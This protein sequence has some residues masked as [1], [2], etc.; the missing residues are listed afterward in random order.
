MH[1]TW[2]SSYFSFLHVV[3][4][5]SGILW[6]YQVHSNQSFLCRT[7]WKRDN[8]DSFPLLGDRQF[9]YLT[10][11]SVGFSKNRRYKLRQKQH[12]DT[13]HEHHQRRLIHRFAIQRSEIYH[14]FKAACSAHIDR[15]DE[16]HDSYTA[17]LSE[18]R[19]KRIILISERHKRTEFHPW[20]SRRPVLC[21]VLSL[22]PFITKFI[23]N[24]TVN[25]RDDDANT[26]TRYTQKHAS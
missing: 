17:K 22:F 20:M 13:T 1:R 14:K 7:Y 21:A 25:L 26:L 15:L 5:C 8:I 2:Q 4:V 6:T 3:Q 11:Q 23:L 16:T 18:A 10:F 9:Y 12:F 19:S 24:D